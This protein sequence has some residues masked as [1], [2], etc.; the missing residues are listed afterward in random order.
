MKQR[1]A[2]LSPREMSVLVSIREGGKTRK[3]VARADRCPPPELTRLVKALESKGLVAVH[4]TGISSS[5]SFS[6]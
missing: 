6:D 4:R 3:T 2:R 1:L 5:I